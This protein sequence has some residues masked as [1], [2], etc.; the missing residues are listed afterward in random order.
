MRVNNDGLI[1]CDMFE[2]LIEPEKCWGDK[3]PI[4]KCEH[5]NVKRVKL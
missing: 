2:I 3:C 4:K 5:C 1:T